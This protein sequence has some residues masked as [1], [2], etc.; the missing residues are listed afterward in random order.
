MQDRPS[1][2]RE[3]AMEHHLQ[4]NRAQGDLLRISPQWTNWTY[5][6][7][8][9][10]FA[11][12]FIYSLF[13]RFD[14]Y[15][16]GIAVIR[17]E[18]RTIVTSITG[19]TIT[20]IAVEPGQRVE[21]NQLLL[22]FN[23]IQE[24]IELERLNRDLNLQQINRLRNPNDS[25]A[26]QQLASVRVQIE[27]LEKRLKERAIFAPRAGM[28]RDIRIRQNQLVSP[29]ELLM[30]ITGDDDALSVIAILPGAYRPL[31]KKGIPL[32][33][34]LNGFRYAY[35]RLIIDAIG[36]E[37]IG[38]SEIRRFLGQE[39][40]DS[41]ALE[42]SSVIIRAHLPSRRFKANGRWHQYHDGMHGTAEARVRSESILLALV[43]GLKA[44]F[45][46]GEESR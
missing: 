39:I 13:G 22:R 41:M 38:P 36:D 31:L 12:G 18:G 2:F 10:V 5:R 6:L 8:V 1:I 15:A 20:G 25:I 46:G 3:E 4:G 45:E 28:V 24:R 7:L 33:L 30:T 26:Q 14:Q 42:G 19:G 27:S 32:R 29:G 23:D 35:Q 43:P 37:V 9:G 21:A 44:V 17:D 40:A 34:E 16:T 11:A